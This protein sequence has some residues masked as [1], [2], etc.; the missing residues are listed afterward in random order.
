MLETDLAAAHEAQRFGDL[1]GDAQGEAL[2]AFDWPELVA[3]IGAAQD[4]RTIVGRGV[5][6]DGAAGGFAGF[7]ALERAPGEPSGANGKRP[8]NRDV[9]I[10]GKAGS[11]RDGAIGKAQTGD[12]HVS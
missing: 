7:A 8:V 6:K 10:Y 1:A 12:G 9:S 4:L 3:R 2:R 5:S 11:A